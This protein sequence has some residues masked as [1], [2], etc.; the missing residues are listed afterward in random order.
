MP[1][2]TVAAPV[3]H[4]L[5]QWRPL[6]N[7]RFSKSL[8]SL[9]TDLS[10][11]HSLCQTRQWRPLLNTRFSKSLDS[12]PTDLSLSHVFALFVMAGFPEVLC[13]GSQALLQD[14]GGDVKPVVVVKHFSEKGEVMVMD[15]RSRRRKTVKD[16]QLDYQVQQEP[17][18]DGERFGKLLTI[19]SGV[20]RE[21]SESREDRN[22]VE[23]VWVLA[24]TLK[25]VLLCIKNDKNGTCT[26]DLVEQGLCPALVQLASKGTGFSRQWLL[27]D[28]EVLGVTLYRPEKPNTEEKGASETSSESEAT[29]ASKEATPDLPVAQGLDPCEGL[30]EA[31]KICFQITH[32]ALGA[33]MPIL[34]A[35]YE[36]HGKQTNDLLDEVQKCFDG[37]AFHASE[38]VRK[39]AAKWQVTSEEPKVE[40]TPED[41]ESRATD[42]GVIPFIPLPM[43]PS[44][45]LVAVE[46]PTTCGEKLIKTSEAE[47][48]DS[49]EKQQR[50]KS[51]ALLKKEVQTHGKA[52]SRKYLYQV[53]M[54]VA[55]LYARH[56]LCSV[57]ANWPESSTIKS[58][59]LGF[60]PGLETHLASL[61]DL[62]Q[63]VV[64]KDDFQQVVENVVTHCGSEMLA[65]FAK[66][67]CQ[68]MEET[69]LATET[70]ESSHPYKSNT[71]ITDKVPDVATE[72]KE[73]AH[74]Y[75][76]NT[77]ITDKVH[78]PNAVFLSVRFDPQCHTEEDCDELAMSSSK[79]LKQDRHVFSGPHNKWAGFDIPGDTLYYKFEGDSSS[80]LW[81]FRFT[82]TGGRS[83]RFNTGY[84]ILNTLLSKSTVFS[85]LPIKLLWEWLVQVACRQ[86]SQQR[87][88]VVELLLR[89]LTACSLRSYGNAPP[90]QDIDLSLLKPLWKL[91]STM[92][93][94]TDSS[95]TILPPL[96]RALTEL[97]IL[98][99]DLAMEWGIEDNYLLQVM[100][101]DAFRKSAAQGLR[102]VAAI[103][104]AIKYKNKATEALER[105]P[106]TPKAP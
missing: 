76:S 89:I 14:N 25:A 38:E 43:K 54:A 60:P 45:H 88:K 90:N 106:A 27:K 15:V 97:F 22:R 24:L 16:Y 12:L 75:K 63:R 9:P 99:E 100:N 13:P 35:I 3:E 103:S 61:L 55:T 19:L 49:Y 92:P 78:I 65:V 2:Q 29:P 31:T 70:K 8:D 95:A 82:V 7:T 85:H 86:T 96:Q 1:D 52:A 64:E 73:S 58:E 26:Q 94:N 59:T 53:N 41:F 18:L 36:L 87:L 83:G 67:T 32:E 77:E 56:V 93:D 4:P 6:L 84:V 102:N 42:V 71:E 20:S 48:R 72:T 57:L 105:A 23:R 104:L 17:V 47:L 69:N 39:M 46:E 33:P 66:A 10:L 21:V 62:L 50:S 30:D 68:F 37:D 34:R 81:G 28:L 40:H 98:A 5:Q 11:S 44:A 80:N 79:D 51:S 74:P 91:Y 101:E